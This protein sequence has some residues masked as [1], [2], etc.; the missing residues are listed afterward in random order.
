MRTLSRIA[1]ALSVSALVLAST[2][3]AMADGGRHR[4][5]VGMHIGS[6]HSGG[7]HGGWNGSA[8]GHGSRG[9]GSYG[10]NF[11][12]GHYR[13]YGSYG[14]GYGYYGY[15]GRGYRHHR[16][17]GGDAALGV[18]LGIVGLAAIAA[19]TSKDRD[20]DDVVYRRDEGYDREGTGWVNPDSQTS[21]PP[22]RQGDQTAYN[23]DSCQQVR[24]YQTQVVIGGKTRDAYGTAC[25]QPDGSWKQF[26]AQLAPEN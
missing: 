25:L 11:G 1:A 2:G 6:G 5:G 22:A 14:P 12:R 20:D 13:G 10:Y 9:T 15:G 7:R 24:E 3:T 23:T 16:G 18:V 17:G 21:A 8:W 26:P 19:A 4:G